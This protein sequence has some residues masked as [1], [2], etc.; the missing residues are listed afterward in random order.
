MSG[1]SDD[2][3]TNLDLDGFG[4][5]LAGIEEHKAVLR[6]RIGP[7]PFAA[8]EREAA[9]LRAELDAP[10][11]RGD[12]VAESVTTIGDLLGGVA[13]DLASGNWVQLDG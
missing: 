12:A 11:P 13:G 8:L 2:G 3:G 5:L 9:R 4:T 6:E 10:A 1:D 7:A